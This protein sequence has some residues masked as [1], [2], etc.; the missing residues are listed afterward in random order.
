MNGGGHMAAA[1]RAHDWATSSLGPFERW[2]AAL[3]FALNLMLNSPESMYLVWGDDR[4]F[5]FND[6]YR[7]ILGPRLDGALGQPFHVLWADAWE[8]VRPSFEKALAGESSRF[9]D[10]PLTLARYGQEEQTWWSFSFSAIHDEAGD[11]AGVLCVT[12]EATQRVRSGDAARRLNATLALQIELRTQERDGV[13]QVSRDM[14]GVANAEGEWV[15]VNPAWQRILGWSPD[16]IVG[17]RAEL[18]LHPDDRARSRAE[19]ARLLAGEL[20]LAFE[21]RLRSRDGSYRHFV[22]NAVPSEGLIYCVA[23]DVTDERKRDEAL[24]DSEDF[25]RLALSSVG[26]VGVWTYEFATERFFYDAA[27]ADLYGIDP[28]QGEGGIA[29]E[30]FLANVSADDRQPLQTVMA[31]SA[32]QG[33][34]VELEYRIRH[35]DGTNRWVLSRGHTYLDETERP[36]R[37]TGVGVDMTKQRILEEQ[38]RQSQK[39]EA[40]GQLTGGVAHDFNNLLTVIKSSTELLQRPNVSEERRA[41][42]IGAIADTVDRAAKLT[43][44]LLAFARR[45]ALR[46][47]TFDAVGSVRS[48]VDMVGTLVGSRIRVSMDLPDEICAISAD[49]SQFDTALVNMA[50]NARDAMD[51]EGALTITVRTVTEI[52]A[53]RAHPK[54]PGDYVAITLTDTG[55]GIPAE[56]MERIFEPFFTTK[57]VGQ[58]T[59]LG[60]SQVFGFAKQSGGEV[61]VESEVGVG[62]TFTLY[63]PHVAAAERKTEVEL[64]PLVEG[65]GTRVL[66]VED[67]ADVGMFAAQ[68]LAEL[69]YVTVLVRSPR[70]ALD[71]LAEGAELFDVVFSDV[72]MPGMSGIEL[73]EQI[74]KLHRSL[75]VVLTSGYSHVL[76][77][78]GT[79]GLDL[80][81]KPYSI[82]QLSRILSRTVRQNQQKRSLPI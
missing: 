81:H 77:E 24:R 58:G 66:V 30:G 61:R 8:Q 78:S 26:G 31:E 16:E 68:T 71:K 76:A 52:P 53:I 33:G 72:V 54:Q 5:F 34:D 11:V 28:A 6:A 43:G 57:D 13:W 67:N 63:L 47:E 27:I 73:A 7:P 69:G 48:L 50:V 75:P 17:Q 12:T 23:R 56:Q 65:H 55:S 79:S 70:E 44:Q 36:V 22:W 9:E 10:R 21:S 59:G 2:P 15:S 29:R 38:L 14:L 82:E 42:Y 64:E 1:I 74:G 3:R 45:Q 41:R 4:L 62:T 60:L 25:A 49:A 51:G 35:P 46:P 19:L 32:I 40:V 20:T 18:L 39:L 80:L 37:R